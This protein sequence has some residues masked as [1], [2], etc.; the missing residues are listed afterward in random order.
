M[1]RALGMCCAAILAMTVQA[2]AA[3]TPPA[4]PAVREWLDRLG[5]ETLFIEPGSPWEN[6]CL[7]SFHGRLR[8][9]L[10]EREI[11][12]SVWEAQ[13][14]VE[15]WRHEYNTV[16]PHSA[17]GYRPPAPEATAWPSG[18]ELFGALHPPSRFAALS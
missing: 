4:A 3:D 2:V 8:D 7:E 5:V 18:S 15:R 16:R 12:D 9:E 1:N 13:V 6:G 10:L 17:L 14:L 11:F